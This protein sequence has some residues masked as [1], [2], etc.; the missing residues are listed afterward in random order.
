MENKFK[1]IGA[2]VGGKCDQENRHIAE[3]KHNLHFV[4]SYK[5]N[6]TCLIKLAVYTVVFE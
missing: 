2:G 5:L 3:N 1:Y 4:M 6:H